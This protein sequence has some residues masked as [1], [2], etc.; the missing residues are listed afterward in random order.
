MTEGTLNTNG[1]AGSRTI[2]NTTKV[3]QYHQSHPATTQITE[4][5]EEGHT[6]REGQ[7]YSVLDKANKIASKYSKEQNDLYR[8]QS[9]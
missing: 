5:S 4:Q 8:D 3:S 2:W 9:R 7:K 1:R 6:R